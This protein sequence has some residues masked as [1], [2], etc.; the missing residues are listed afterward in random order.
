MI[1]DVNKIA[2][3]PLDERVEALNEARAALHS[4]ATNLVLGD[5]EGEE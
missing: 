5:D 1:I 2:E 4:A 3:L